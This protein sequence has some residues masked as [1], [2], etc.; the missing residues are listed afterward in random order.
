MP[1]AW[2]KDETKDVLLEAAWLTLVEGS[3][4]GHVNLDIARV[5]AL[6]ADIWAER[7]PAT[8][9]RTFTRGA[10]IN[11]WETVGEFQRECLL[12]KLHALQR[13]R[14]A[15]IT[16]LHRQLM[17]AKK[18][19]LESRASAAKEALTI[20]GEQQFLIHAKGPE[21]THYLRL[22]SRHGLTD[23]QTDIHRMYATWEKLTLPSFALACSLMGRTL[24]PKS[25]AVMITAIIEGAATRAVVDGSTQIDLHELV[26]QLVASVPETLGQGSA[27][28]EAGPLH[29]SRGS[30]TQ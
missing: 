8:Q 14:N 12:T 21:L 1:R 11:I 13:E 28:A 20:F 16:T 6:A 25:M 17:Q 24:D 5:L 15:G 22:L 2:S 23:V 10:V 30:K 29:K 26:G 18:L 3:K 9:R 27:V 7:H 19:P 4:T